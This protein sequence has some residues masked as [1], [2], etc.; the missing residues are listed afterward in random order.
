MV[1]E[2]SFTKLAEALTP[3]VYGECFATVGKP[4][5]LANVVQWPTAFQ[6]L[7]PLDQTILSKTSV[8]ATR[9]FNNTQLASRPMAAIKAYFAVQ[10]AKLLF[11]FG[12]LL[13][14]EPWRHTVLLE[15]LNDQS[16]S[17]AAQGRCFVLY[18]LGLR[19]RCID[20]LSAHSLGLNF[21]QTSMQRTNTLVESTGLQINL[22]TARLLLYTGLQPSY[23]CI[24]NTNDFASTQAAY[25]LEAL[26]HVS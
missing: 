26:I 10:T 16:H 13:Q 17:Y 2:E 20:G 23:L 21:F 19:C 4:S 9:R 11:F 22:D 7:L 14:A 15:P 8:D 1:P 3:V 6:A 12:Q 5:P 18:E 24:S 25:H